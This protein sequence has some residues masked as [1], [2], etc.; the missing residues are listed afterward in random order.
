[1][2]MLPVDT[3]AFWHHDMEAHRDNCFYED[4]P[5]VALGIRMSNEC[6][7]AELGEEGDPWG[8][9]PRDRRIDLNKRYSD[10]AETIV[11]RRLLP[12]ELPY[13]DEMFPPIRR[14]GEVFGGTYEQGV[15][16][17]EWL[18]SPIE[19][20]RELEK[21][22]DDVDRTD[23]R[24]FMLPKNWES[25]KIRIFETYGKKPPLMRGIR[26][27]VTLAMSIYG[28][29]NLIFLYYDA[30][31]LFARFSETIG[32]VVLEMGKVM[33]TEA[34]YSPDHVPPGFS[35][36]DDECALLTPE[37]YE[38]FGYPILKNVFDYYSPEPGDRRYQHSDSA[39]GHIVPILGRLKLTGCNFGPTVLVNDIRP[40]MPRTRIDGCLA[41]FTFMNN[42]TDDIIEE[43]RRDCEMI[44]ATGTKGLNLRTAGSINNGSLLTS[45]HTVMW[46]IL[47]YGRY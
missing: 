19:T 5:Q 6:V 14:I 31:N 33:D 4:A 34:G 11:G 36:A 41:P 9:E 27:P 37:M 13:D 12:E 1:M 3:E 20:P 10:K 17:G 38:V 7:Y 45:M 21:M 23:L 43:V 2:D 40:H 15:K 30:P 26:G 25:E 35:F 28:N 29:E 22:L 18:H 39:M 8:Q 46:A 47:E 24:E 42:N 32:R 16:T 44:K